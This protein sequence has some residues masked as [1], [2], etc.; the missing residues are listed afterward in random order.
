MVRSAADFWRTLP[1]PSKASSAYPAYFAYQVTAV[2]G[3]VVDIAQ[4]ERVP[5]AVFSPP[6][7]DF[8]L[9]TPSTRHQTPFTRTFA[10]PLD[11]GTAL[12]S[13]SIA[14]VSTIFA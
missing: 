7:S 10:L 5:L 3:A 8:A 4:G 14:Y 6:T 13:R 9:Q 12:T 1:I 11:D 2:F